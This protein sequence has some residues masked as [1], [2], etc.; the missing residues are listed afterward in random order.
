M[1]KENA[2]TEDDQANGEKKVQTLTDKYCAEIDNLC[3]AKEIENMAEEDSTEENILRL[4]E[5]YE[6]R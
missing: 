1:K 5:D 3:T 2:I 4:I 6:D